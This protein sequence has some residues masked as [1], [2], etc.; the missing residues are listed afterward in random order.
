MEEDEEETSLRRWT[1]EESKPPLPLTLQKAREVGKV[2]RYKLNK[3]EE[4]NDKGSEYTDENRNLTQLTQYR[5]DTPMI[6]ST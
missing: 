2:G 3:R 1:D 4:T 6:S 5:F